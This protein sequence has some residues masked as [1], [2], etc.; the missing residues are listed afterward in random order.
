MKSINFKFY[1]GQE[2]LTP[3]G[4]LGIVVMLQ[5]GYGGN[6]YYVIT[7]TNRNWYVE[8]L[9]KDARPDIELTRLSHC[10]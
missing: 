9:L 10:V 6:S 2:V 5:Y 3:L 7:K 4:C 8:K 1:L